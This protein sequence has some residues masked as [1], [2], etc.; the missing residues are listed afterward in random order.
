[1]GGTDLIDQRISY[2]FPTI[3]SVHW[4]PRIFIHVIYVCIVNSFILYRLIFKS[5]DKRYSLKN[6]IGQLIDSLAE[7]QRLLNQNVEQPISGTKYGNRDAYNK[8]KDRLFGLHCPTQKMKCDRNVQRSINNRA[9]SRY[10]RGCCIICKQKVNTLCE[11][12]NVFLCLHTHEN[13]RSCWKRAHYDVNVLEPRD[14][15]DEESD[16]D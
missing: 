13:T 6:Y 12:C 1:M 14:S 9:D 5:A 3:K 15:S 11:T 8:S 16:L 2:Y 10:K 7:E 4:Q